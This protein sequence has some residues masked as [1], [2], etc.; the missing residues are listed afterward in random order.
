MT[1]TSKSFT[2]SGRVGL[3]GQHPHVAGA[4]LPGD[5]TTFGRTGKH[6]DSAKKTQFVWPQPRN[7]ALPRD[8]TGF[9]SRSITVVRGICY[10]LFAVKLCTPCLN[11][12]AWYV[13][14]FPFGGGCAIPLAMR[15]PFC[16]FQS[17]A[18]GHQALWGRLERHNDA[19]VLG[20]RGPGNIP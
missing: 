12:N 10:A 15:S 1:T 13:T 4:K 7:V 6:L 11:P 8:L 2:A 19:C 20:G 14:Y 18:W 9:A 5:M 16:L 3:A 17:S